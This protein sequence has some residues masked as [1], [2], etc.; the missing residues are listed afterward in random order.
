[1]GIVST[2][3]KAKNLLANRAGAELRYWR[4]RRKY[5]K[6]A[7][8][9]YE[10]IWVDP[11]SIKDCTLP[12]LKGQL[13]IST[14]GSHVIG[15]EWDRR[16]RYDDVWYNRWLG[17]PVIAEFEQHALY[18]AMENHFENQVP[19]EETKWYQWVEENPGVAGQYNDVPTMEE[20][21]SKVDDLYEY[22]RSEGYKTHRELIETEGS[23]LETELLPAPEHHEIDVNIGRDGNLFFNFNG[24]HR[25]AIAKILGLE[26]VPVRV[27]VRHKQW[28]QRR[29][30]ATAAVKTEQD[31][32]DH[33]DINT[34]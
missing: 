4:Y 26:E 18:Q 34:Y 14:C 15:G 12:S 2:A 30:E 8:K 24:R 23:P 27:F 21:L 19:W 29:T 3:R 6:A 25:L 31:W 7:P 13:G 9:P 33:P 32:M 20:R 22:I 1:M 17:R 10:I 16:P 11:D 5:G 28:Q